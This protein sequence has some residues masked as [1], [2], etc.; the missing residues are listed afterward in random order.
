MFPSSVQTKWFP[1]YKNSNGATP[2]LDN[3]RDSWSD[4]NARNA[5]Y[6]NDGI[7]TPTSK[8]GR[9][10]TD[11]RDPVVHPADYDSQL[12]EDYKHPFNAANEENLYVDEKKQRRSRRTRMVVVFIFLSCLIVSLA[13]AATV[14]F[15]SMLGK[16][17]GVEGGGGA[18]WSVEVG[19]LWRVEVGGCTLRSSFSGTFL[20]T[21]PDL[22]TLLKGHSLSPRSCP[23]TRSAPSERFGY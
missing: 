22:V 4:T 8:N 19:A 14:V 6:H 17:Q 13:I 1:D 16:K 11:H 21:L 18:L 2:D 12:A 10:F 23:P 15:T 9:R 5:G 7:S 3:H 20:Q